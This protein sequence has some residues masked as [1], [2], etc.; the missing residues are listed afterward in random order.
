M[1]IEADLHIHTVASG[2]AFS[3]VFENA[4]AAAEKGLKLIAITDHGPGLPGG[5][6]SFYFWNLRII[7]PEINGVKILRGIE[8][9]IV[10]A[11]GNI[12]LAQELL[13]PLDI[14]H[15]ALHTHCGYEDRGA[16]KN[17]DT[18][19]KAMQN[20]LVDVLVHPGNPKFPINAKRLVRA[21]R[22]NEVLLEVNNS[23]FLTGTSRAGSYELDLAIIKEAKKLGLEIVVGSDAHFKD[24][25]GNFGA[26]LDLINSV[27]FP[28]DRIL[29][30]SSEKVICHLEKKKS[31]K[32]F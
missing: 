7:P 6:H 21:A 20:P 19:I 8:A 1:K 2:H 3:T 25:V 18:I 28:V 13:E 9:N 22:E 27:H 16:E 15:L 10:D 12:D 5:A 4:E 23:S 11:E 30:T 14:I 29:N 24:A 31:R 17:T 26:A 32:L